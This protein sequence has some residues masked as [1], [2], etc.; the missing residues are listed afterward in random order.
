[1][2][3]IWKKLSNL[4]KKEKKLEVQIEPEVNFET[5]PERYKIVNPSVFLIGCPSSK[6][7]VET[8]WLLQ[9]CQGTDYWTIRHY[10]EIYSEMLTI[11]A[12]EGKEVFELIAVDNKNTWK[13][14]NTLMQNVKGFELLGEESYQEND[15]MKIREG[16]V[17]NSSSSSFI[18]AVPNI[19]KTKTAQVNIDCYNDRI[20]ELKDEI[21]HAEEEEK[22]D[23]KYELEGIQNE[24]D[25]FK[26]LSID[27]ELTI[28]DINLEYGAGDILEVLER[29]IPGFRV[30]TELE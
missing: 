18:C 16:F 3:N 14:L 20:K 5:S 24:I 26:E 4:F 8:P 17:S 30:L 13:L 2:K 15:E 1:M 27:E 23:L 11:S 22:E 6:P 28:F 29:K 25:G 7:K 10:R 12:T 19:K 21:R 9:S